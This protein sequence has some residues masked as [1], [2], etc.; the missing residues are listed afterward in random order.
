MEFVFFIVL[1]LVLALVFWLLNR[2]IVHLAYP[3]DRRYQHL[4]LIVAVFLI[5]LL[6]TNGI[7]V[8]FPLMLIDALINSDFLGPIL[9]SILPARSYDLEY[10]LLTIVL[11]N[12]MVTLL[13]IVT[14]VVVKLIFGRRS[15]GGSVNGIAQ[16]FYEDGG[17]GP[18]LNAAGFVAGR[19]AAGMKLA[20]L[21]LWVAEGVVLGASILWGG[22]NWNQVILSVSKAWYLLPMA[23]FLLAEQ[24]QLFL[25][26]SFEETAGSFGSSEIPSYV[27]GDNMPAVMQLYQDCFGSSLLYSEMG[28][29][30]EVSRTGMRSNDLGNQQVRD[31]SQPEVLKV[32][33]T[34]LS[35]CG[36]QKCDEY[37]NA[38]VTLLNHGSINVRDDSRGE[39][40]TYLSSYLNYFLSQGRTVLVLCENDAAAERM[41]AGFRERM[42]RLNDLHSVWNICTGKEARTKS[43]VSMAVC[44]YEDFLNQQILAAH[45]EF[46]EDLFCVVIADGADLMSRDGIRVEQIFHSLRMLKRPA[47]EPPLQYVVFSGVDNDSLRTS[48]EGSIQQAGTELIPFKHDVRLKNTGLMVWREESVYKVQRAL[49]I[50]GEASPHM[51]T[52]IPLAL[53]AA[54]YDLPRVYLIPSPDRGENTF[55]EILTL[56]DQQVRRFLK[57]DL[58]LTDLF[59]FDPEEAIRRQDISLMIAY[60]TDYNFCNALWRWM[61]YGGEQATLLHMISPPYLLRD[62]F[63]A[64]M[65]EKQMLLRGFE[66]SAM[67]P[68]HSA[69]RETQLALLLVRLSDSGMTEEELMAESRRHGWEYETA[70][71]LLRAC[72]LVVLRQEEQHSVYSCFSFTHDGKK[73]LREDTDEYLDPTVITLTD[74][75]IRRRLLEEVRYADFVSKKNVRTQLPILRGNLFNY[76]LP[77]QQIVVDGYVCQIQEIRDG[78]VYAEQDTPSSLYDYYPISDFTFEDYT[79]INPC[80]DLDVMDMNLFRATTR[81]R[82]FGYVASNNGNRFAD[83]DCINVMDLRSRG[84]VQEDNGSSI[85]ELNFRRD[86]LGGDAEG[87]AVLAAYMIREIAKTLFPATWQNLHVATELPMDGAAFTAVLEKKDQCPVEDLVRSVIPWVT[88][89][90]DVARPDFVTIYVVEL[91][92][93]EYGM[94]QTLYDRWEQLFGI[95]REYLSWYLQPPAAASA[96]PG[97]TGAAFAAPGFVSGSAGNIFSTPGAG[98]DRKAAFSLDDTDQTEEPAGDD[99]Q[100]G[101][102]DPRSFLRASAKPILSQNPAAPAQPPAGAPAS[103]VIDTPEVKPEYLHFGADTVPD[104]FAPDALLQLCERVLPKYEQAEA[105]TDEDKLKANKTCTFCGSTVLFLHHLADGREMCNDC[106]NHQL[107]QQDEIKQL[108]QQTVQYMNQGYGIKLTDRLH[109]RFKSADE[110][111]EVTGTPIDGRVLGFY[112]PKT[113]QLWIEG[114][115]P[116][117]SMQ[118]TLAHELTHVWQYDCLPIRRLRAK[119]PRATRDRTLLCIQEGHAVYVEID[120]MRKMHE[121]TYANFMTALSMQR[122]D[123]Y[124]IGFQWIC[125]LMEAKQTEGSYQNAFYSMREIVDEII[126]GKVA[127]P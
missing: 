72:L 63:A 43:R 42:E 70:E 20:F 48:L 103:P 114:R 104:L 78:T 60:D 44:S 56:N 83:R 53:V 113:R 99:G 123:E 19:W 124:G 46:R 109:I 24:I 55:R 27:D 16:R 65:Q 36:V 76:H 68:H 107:T 80:V 81:R 21:L 17:G 38:L 118:S 57:K 35:E 8:S 102:N 2:C 69:I 33:D 40:L 11:L 67:V 71:E 82:I 51:G 86:A 95:L 18:K 26:G 4:R 30:D 77:G 6:L 50:G 59:R 105:P 32:L 93:L 98:P 115:G 9:S 45:A 74:E 64:N 22:E 91:S 121:E 120:V 61:K 31:C 94:V 41:C 87:A 7:T 10:M 126:A 100:G 12:L 92:C 116:R 37:M 47:D 85:L 52:A 96:V 23:G 125:K 117:I 84:I 66:F 101:E 106:K 14:I 90:P 111:R 49:N 62:Y 73:V 29:R 88:A 25:E 127:L 58:N 112:S 108:Y 15:E 28:G 119:L 13:V 97:G 54:K 34:Q 5:L 75:N 79:L 3:L 122:K 39:F 110:I 89:R 1:Y